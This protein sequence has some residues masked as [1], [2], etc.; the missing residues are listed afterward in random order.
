MKFHF[1]TYSLVM[2]LIPTIIALIDPIVGALIMLGYIPFHAFVMAWVNYYHIKKDG[3]ELMIIAPGLALGLMLISIY[4]FFE[5]S[6][7]INV[8]Y[9]LDMF[10]IL[11]LVL[12]IYNLILSKCFGI[13][14]NIFLLTTVFFAGIMASPIFIQEYFFLTYGVISGLYLDLCYGLEISDPKIRE[15]LPFLIGKWSS[16]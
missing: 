10:F 8:P 3:S 11:A 6:R 13:K 14:M 15:K 12:V 16:S 5:F 4:G 1:T 9:G 7:N 2:G